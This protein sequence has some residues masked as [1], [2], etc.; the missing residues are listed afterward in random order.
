MKIVLRTN[1]TIAMMD[2]TLEATRPLAAH[3]WGKEERINEKISDYDFLPTRRV[4]GFDWSVCQYDIL[5]LYLFFRIIS[6]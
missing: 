2:C 6:D 4:V 5:Y 3:L 1:F